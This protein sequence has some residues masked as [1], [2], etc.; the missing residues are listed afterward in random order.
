MTTL[1]EKIIAA[2]YNTIREFICNGGAGGGIM[3]EVDKLVAVIKD[4]HIKAEIVES[5]LKAEIVESTLKATII[6]EPQN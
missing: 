4:E 6:D 5:T 3:V 1:R 2:G